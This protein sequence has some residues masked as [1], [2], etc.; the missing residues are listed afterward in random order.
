[1]GDS[2]LSTLNCNIGCHVQL[3]INLLMLRL[4]EHVM[5]EKF[6]LER[7]PS[8]MHRNMLCVLINESLCIK[9]VLC[10]DVL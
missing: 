2:N 4:T 7:Q 6:V 5:G 3:F 9:K 10:A 1:M 8:S